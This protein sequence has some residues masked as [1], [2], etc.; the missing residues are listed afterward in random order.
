MRWKARLRGLGALGVV[1]CVVARYALVLHASAGWSLVAG[2]MSEARKAPVAVALDDGRVLA[3]GGVHLGG[4]SSAVDVYDSQTNRWIAPAAPL[5]TGRFFHAAAALRNGC[6]L[7]TAGLNGGGFLS[8]TEIYNPA[9]DTWTQGADLP[10]PTFAPKAVTLRDGRVFVIGGFTS[11]GTT[12]ATAFYDPAADA[13]TSGPPMSFARV[14]PE[15]TTLV[16]GDRFVVAAGLA[17][18]DPFAMFDTGEAY[19][20]NGPPI[21]VASADPPAPEGVSGALTA[22]MVSAAASSDPDN[23]PLTFTWTEGTSTLART[24]DPA[25]T[26]IIGLAVG[27]HTLTL[28]VDDGV[29]GVS[30]ATLAVT[31][32][33]ATAPLQ[34]LIAT[35]AAQIASLQRTIA[36]AVR[37]IQAN[38][39]ASFHDPSF[40]IPGRT[41]EDQLQAVVQAVVQLS[42]ECRRHVYMALRRTPQ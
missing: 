22:I 4:A 33:D 41:P 15:A 40:T 38:L 10:F 18:R 19:T 26:S 29:G 5:H 21:A 35:Q 32:R 30:T 27:V 6:V 25:R 7:V 31:V 8:S 36:D 2:T 42:K 9:Q 16:V 34:A 11:D 13:W 23:D 1:A 39:S 37:T 14:L 20:V 28:T 17:V 12:N 3:I 24:T